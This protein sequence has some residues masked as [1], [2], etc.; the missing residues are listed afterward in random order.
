[1]D[2]TEALKTIRVLIDVASESDD[3]YFIHKQLRAM[4][5]VVDNTSPPDKRPFPPLRSVDE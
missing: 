1:M 5:N 2:P 3:I 4:R